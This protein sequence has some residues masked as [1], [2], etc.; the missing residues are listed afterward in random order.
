LD[1]F[2]PKK[3]L[4]CGKAGAYICNSCLEKIEI[5]KSNKCPVCDRPIPKGQICL[6]CQKKTSL[7][8][9]CW[10]APY[11]NSLTQQ[12]IKIFKYHYVK[13]LAQPLSRLLIKCLTPGVKHGALV[14]PIPLHKRRLREREFN[15][16]ELLAKQVAEYFSLPLENNVLIRKKYTPQQARTRPHKERR[17]ALKNVFEINPEFTKKCLSQ[18]KN[19]LNN[20][21]IILVDD[22]FTSGATMSEAAK[23]L[24][25]A[26][27]KEIWGLVI[28]KG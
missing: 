9:L 4:N 13:E 8:R 16:A 6:F 15:Q 17:Q 2:F 7:N 23:V 27:A 22:V 18:N 25:R 3:C 28:A 10:A 1:I 19:L 20:K 26:G 24:R 5:D 11:S 14:V 12:L 21:T